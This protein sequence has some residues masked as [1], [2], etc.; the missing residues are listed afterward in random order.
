MYI[1][2]DFISSIGLM[3]HCN[4][5]MLSYVKLRYTGKQYMWAVL[6]AAFLFIC[7]WDELM[8]ITWT[9]HAVFSLFSF[10]F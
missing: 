10:D 8:W 4:I 3:H 5:T 2:V 1:K 9:S 6:F 7:Q